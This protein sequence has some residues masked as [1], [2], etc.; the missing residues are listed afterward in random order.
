MR[1]TFASVEY[2]HWW[3]KGRHLP[4]LVTTSPIPTAQAD[5][6]VLGEPNTTTLFGDENIGGDLQAAGRLTVG[7]WLDE[8]ASVGV[9][10][11]V[12]GVEGHNSGFSRFSDGTSI[13][14]VPFFNED[15][16]VDAEDA[17]LVGFPNLS[18]GSVNV[19]AENEVFG[20]QIFMR[21]M[22]DQG[23]D[24]R[25]DML[26]GYRFNRINDDLQIVENITDNFLNQFTFSD[27]FQTRNEYHAGEI[28]LIGEYQCGR[29]T[30][31][32]LGSISY[33]SMN[34]RVTISG[35]NSITAGG[36]VTTPGGLFAQ[37]TNIGDYERNLTAWCPEAGVKMA[38]AVTPRLSVSV[39]YTFLYWSRIAL[40]GDQIDRNVNGTQLNGGLPGRSRTARP[41]SAPTPTS[42]SRRSTS[43]PA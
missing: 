26:L 8:A 31:S 2:L 21:H 4:P 36:T 1:A 9:G 15:P 42:G 37:P 40:A 20:G 6:G 16:L 41:S 10:V 24:Y 30:Y 23:R 34:Q 19:W 5:A 7:M 13:L 28:G 27:L 32:G 43:A 14:A 39:G 17:L 11:R 3:N 29:W 22:L 25:L 38:Y 33:G 35:E 18:Q 12:F